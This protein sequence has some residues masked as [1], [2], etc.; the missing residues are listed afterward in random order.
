[1]PFYTLAI[2]WSL[3][4]ILGKSYQGNS[5]V[6]GLNARVIAKYSDVGLVEGYMS[7]TVQDTA[8]GTIND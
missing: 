2:R 6:R 5:S 4:K 7:E 8:S 3:C 1:M